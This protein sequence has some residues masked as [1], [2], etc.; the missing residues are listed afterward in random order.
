[1]VV[2]CQK[3]LRIIQKDT[4]VGASNVIIILKDYSRKGGS[5]KNA[6]TNRKMQIPKLEHNHE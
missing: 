2:T 6:K 5:V 4:H 3:T 1:M